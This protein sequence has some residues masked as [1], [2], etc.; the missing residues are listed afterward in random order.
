MQRVMS[1][2][3]V[4]AIINRPWAVSNRPYNPDHTFAKL[5][6]AFA[7]SFLPVFFRQI[8]ESEGT[9]RLTLCS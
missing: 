9:V 4:G 8:T 2:N 5:P 3:F 7:G 1:I 6:Y